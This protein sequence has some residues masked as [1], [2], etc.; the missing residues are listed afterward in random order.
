MSISFVWDQNK[1]TLNKRKHGISFEET[2][3]L[4]L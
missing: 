4:F 1:N 2:K 3:K